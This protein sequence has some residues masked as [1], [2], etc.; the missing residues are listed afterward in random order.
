ME[1]ISNLIGETVIRFVSIE[2][3][4]SNIFFELGFSKEKL[5]LFANSQ[6]SRKLNSFI[7]KLNKSELKNK[8]EYISII[9]K[10]NKLREERNIIVHSLVLRN[11]DN[12]E[13]FMFNNYTSF[14]G[15]IKNTSKQYNL[16]DIEKLILQLHEIEKDLYQLHFRT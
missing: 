12:E 10:F 9:E 6:T 5:K 11:A 15:E 2:F 4:L 7:S 16:K 8:Q 1:K 14:G 3:A 13:N